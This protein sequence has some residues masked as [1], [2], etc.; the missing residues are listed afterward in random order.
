MNEYG[1]DWKDHRGS[2]LNSARYVSNPRRRAACGEVGLYDL[3][4]DGVMQGEEM[5]IS[6]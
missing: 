1:R 4:P 3:V 6:W 2:I 5:Y